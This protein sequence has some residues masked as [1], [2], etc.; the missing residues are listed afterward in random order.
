MTNIQ[1]SSKFYQN[2]FRSEYHKINFFT[3]NEWIEGGDSYIYGKYKIRVGDWNH[4]GIGDDVHFF[5]PNFNT[6]S[7][8]Q[9]FSPVRYRLK[10]IGDYSIN[11]TS[12]YKNTSNNQEFVEN[13]APDVNNPSVE[14]PHW[15]NYLFLT[16]KSERDKMLIVNTIN[17]KSWY[18]YLDKKDESLKRT[19]FDGLPNLGENYKYDYYLSKNYFLENFDYGYHENTKLKFYNLIENKT[20]QDI[21][22]IVIK[23]VDVYDGI[24]QHS[25]TEFNYN[26]FKTLN[27]GSTYYGEVIIEKKGN[28][29]SSLGKTFNY[30]NTGDTDLRKLGLL[31]RTVIKDTKGKTVQEYLT[32]MNAGS[33]L[34]ENNSENKSVSIGNRLLQNK[35]INHSYFYKNSLQNVF[36]SQ[37]EY[38]YNENGLIS[39]TKKT[40]SKG[41]LEEQIIE[42]AYENSIDFKTKNMLIAVS[43]RTSKINNEKVWVSLAEWTNENGKL[44]P[45]K[46]FKGPTEDDLRLISEITKISEKG[47]VEETTNGKGLYAV[48]LSGYNYKRSVASID[49]ARFTEVINNL[50]VSY[51]QLQSLNNSQLRVELMKLYNRLPNAMIKLSFYDG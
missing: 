24:S 22:D 20:G 3:G 47:V 26:N 50:D 37:E 45:N 46:D 18:F 30:Y 25:I 36:T 17:P 7:S 14:D 29:T 49:N 1:F 13:Y 42:Y 39:K 32:E 40:N 43:K 33:D 10:N 6:F 34:F 31:E 38:D 28:G 19:L 44:Y 23:S 5:D 11:H 27:D 8:I 21:Y 35:K 9:T 41:L 48:N 51:N 4:L 15:Q 16:S 2:N 12:I